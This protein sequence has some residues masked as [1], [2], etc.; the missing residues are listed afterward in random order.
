MLSSYELS[1]KIEF[2]IRICDLTPN[3]HIGFTIYDLSRSS[4]MGPLASTMIDVFDNKERMRQGTFNLFLWKD[5]TLDI[6][7]NSQT[8]GLFESNPEDT[9][10]DQ[11]TS[12]GDLTI[13]QKNF[14]EINRLI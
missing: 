5:K 13:S 2:P 10:V 14:V 4:A 8:P 7:I 11:V 9:L 6:S 12:E 3:T 1:Q